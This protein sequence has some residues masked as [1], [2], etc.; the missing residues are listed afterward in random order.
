[1]ELKI[2]LDNIITP[3]FRRAFLD[4]VNCNVNEVV[5][6]GGR[7][8]VKSV[9]AANAIIIG[10][11]MHK[12]SAICILQTGN[13]IEGRLVN[14]FRSSIERLG[15][16]RFWDYKKSPKHKLTLL[17]ENGRLT[18]HQIIFSGAKNPENLKGVG[19]IN[20]GFRYL[21]IEELTNFDSYNDVHNVMQTTLRGVGD[22]TVI[23][24][25]N[26]PLHKSSWVNKMYDR[27]VGKVLGNKKDW[28][29]EGYDYDIGNGEIEH[30]KRLIHHSTLYNVLDAGHRDWLGDE[31]RLAAMSKQDNPKFW[32]WIYLG[33]VEGTDATVFWN[34]HEYDADLFDKS[35]IMQVNRGMDFGYGGPDASCFV[36]WYYDRKN[37]S[38]YALDEFYAPKLTLDQIESELKRVNPNNFPVY[39]DSAV[40]LLTQN[41]NSR[42]L[43]LLNV[44]K[45]PGSVEAGILWLQSLNGIYIDKNKTPNIWREFNNYEYLLNKEYEVTSKLSGDNDHTIAATR[46]AFCQEIRVK[47]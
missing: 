1:M 25:Y 37:N 45:P 11:M 27:P 19:G 24:A 44:K 21:F 12:A 40:P 14:T 31:P 46:Y 29:Y 6:K 43:F 28:V 5:F 32:R 18:N 2:S 9:T 33:S 7:A 41:L 20:E 23:F 8:S 35:K 30:G 15:V 36:S 34:I 4:I 10:C 42:G 16:G 17:D 3:N 22:H 38:I 13:D 26:P 47:V 39:A